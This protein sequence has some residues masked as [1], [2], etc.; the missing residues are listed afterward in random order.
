MENTAF[1]HSI[2][3]SVSPLGITMKIDIDI[4]YKNKET[5]HYQTETVSDAIGFLEAIMQSSVDEKE[6]EYKTG[7]EKIAKELKDEYE[8]V[9]PIKK[10]HLRIKSPNQEP[11]YVREVEA[12][13]KESA[14]KKF[15]QDFP[16]AMKAEWDWEYLV[17]KIT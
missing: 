2:S 5:T 9:M 3:R 12:T 11:D 13:S 4:K 7:I 10:Y 1:T 14:A 16:F 6:A 8:D 17:D 15:F